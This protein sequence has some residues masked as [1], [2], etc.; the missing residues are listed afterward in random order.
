MSRVVLGCERL[1]ADA[2]LLRDR[3]V[4]LIT[5]HSGVDAHLQST[6]DRLHQSEPLCA[7]RLVR[8]GARDPR[9][10]AGTASTSPI[11]R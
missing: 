4:G 7:R 9:R 1:L 5:N 2:D 10:S 8:A 3:R 11:H 6:A